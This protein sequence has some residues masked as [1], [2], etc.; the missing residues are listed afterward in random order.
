MMIL[1]Q[2]LGLNHALYNADVVEGIRGLPDC[3][4]GMSVYSPPFASLY[5]FSN[6][7]RDM[8]NCKKQ[9]EF[10]IAYK[11]LIEQMLRVHK[12]GRLSAVHCMNLPTSKVRDGIIG[13]TDFRGEIIRAH[14]A[15]GWIYH[16]EV[17]IWKDPIVAMSRTKALGLLHKTAKRDATLSRQGLAEYVVVFR[18]PGDNPEPVTHIGD[19]TDL[20]VSL[21]SRYASPVWALTGAASPDGFYDIKQDINPSDTLQYQSARDNDDERHISALQLEVIR[22]AIK[23][24]SNAG[25]VVL[26]PFA[27][28]GS[29]GYVALELGRKYVGFELK[30]SYYDVAKKNLAKAEPNATGKQQALFAL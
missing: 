13:L 10:A 15:A 5:T 17:V 7:D 19:D 8:G 23:L 2:S 4:V 21:W 6:S 9:D 29:E 16:S 30:R 3:S 26:S 14:Q 18:K 20:P 25:D 1:D 22:R 27:G 12:P 11:H 28:I 24:W